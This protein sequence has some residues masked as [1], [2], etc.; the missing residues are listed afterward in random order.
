MRPTFLLLAVLLLAGCAGTPPS[1]ADLQ[2]AET[3]QAPAG[4][5]PFNTLTYS[6]SKE[7][8]HA[9]VWA[10]G[11]MNAQD[12]C[13]VGGCVFDA[14][15]AMRVTDLTGVVPQG[16][17][18]LLSA[19]LEWNE[20]AVSVGGW[21]FFIEAPDSVIYTER[22][23]AQA[24]HVEAQAVLRPAGAV[25]V[26][27]LAYGPG[28]DLPATAYTL[29]ISIESE[30]HV[31]LPGVPVSIPLQGGDTL[32]AGSYGGGDASFL[33]Y[34]PDESRLGLFKGRHTLPDSAPTGRYVLLLPL[35]GP[36]GNV[37]TDSGAE[38]MT[39]LGLRQEMGPESTV[40]PSG[41]LDAAWD[42]TGS[43]LGFGLRASA[44]EDLVVTSF[45]VAV[46]L[47]AKLQGPGG[48]VFDG[49]EMCG[50]CVTGGFSNTVETGTGDPAIVAGT[51]TVHAESQGSVGMRIQPFAIYLDR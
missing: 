13:N 47:T 23:T 42:V 14:S 43:P 30:P 27:L 2:Q 31:L 33:L 20:G 19:T 7:G 11:T 37:S 24:G 49:G 16:V 10:N 4:A 44:G 38:S 39:A 3:G 9:V 17:P 6:G 25:S 36:T 26:V 8:L 5:K 18:T 48:Y 40:P 15:K 28:A 12:T 34:G 45:T 21:A 1:P 35:G 50:L 51:Y 22:S 41:A 46:G 29:R 32:R